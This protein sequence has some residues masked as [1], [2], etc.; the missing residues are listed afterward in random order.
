MDGPKLRATPDKTR[1]INLQ[2]KT[3]S[4]L[5]FSFLYSLPPYK[6]LKSTSPIFH[7]PYTRHHNLS[8][9]LTSLV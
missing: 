6:K 3:V 1:S 4:I 8:L 7:L 9:L 2:G 5:I